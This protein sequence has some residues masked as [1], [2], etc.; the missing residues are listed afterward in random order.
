MFNSTTGHLRGTWHNFAI[1]SVGKVG[2]LFS[3]NKK[4]IGSVTR[5]RNDIHHKFVK[6]ARI[7]SEGLNEV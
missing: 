2:Q 3:R 7:P 4:G 6:D 1:V 5:N